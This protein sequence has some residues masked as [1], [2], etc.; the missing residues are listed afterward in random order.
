MRL[1]VAACEERSFTAAAAREHA[2]QSGVS[3]H[4]A[5]LERQF[6]VRLFER[7]KGSVTPT[8]AGE[9]FYRRC[10]DV[11]RAHE[12]ASRALTTL[13]K[14]LAGEVRVGLMPTMTRAALAPA[15]L[16]FQDDNP[17]VKVQIVEAYSGVLT[18][19]VRAGA[20]DFAIVP[21]FAGQAG[22]RVR[23]FLTTRETLV[24]RRGRQSRHWHPVRLSELGPLKIVLPGPDNTRRQTLET[25]CATN[26][27]EIARTMELDAMM[28]T[29]DIVATSDW[30]SVLPG[31]MMAGEAGESPF[32]VR[33]IDDPPLFLD[34]VV[35][36]PARRQMR[37]EAA[38][39][40]SVLAEETRRLN[41]PWAN[42]PL[43]R[44]RV[45]AR[46]PGS[47]TGP[48]ERRKRVRP[49]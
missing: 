49:G 44:V 21:A 25:Y 47:H 37:P 38:A 15:L 32:S 26:G 34:L 2:T 4:V 45:T 11:L 9:A 20:Y 16:A 22:V 43:P 13:A 29:L 30:V 42:G 14:G 39:F 17:N 7:A 6:G 28:G 35:I 23:S 1:F 31:I 18:R 40:F 10:L 5:K 48:S 33:P 19:E 36:E 27:V 12:A 24:S 3:Q 8:A 41:R 46:H